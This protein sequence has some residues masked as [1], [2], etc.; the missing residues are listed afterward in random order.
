MGEEDY[1]KKMKHYLDTLKTNELKTGED[2]LKDILPSDIK[3]DE[4]QKT[5]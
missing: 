1:K 5:K 4:K 3:F 2:F